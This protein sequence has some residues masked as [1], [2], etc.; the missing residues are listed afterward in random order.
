MGGSGHGLLALRVEA[1]VL[2]KAVDEDAE[3]GFDLKRF[4][5]NSFFLGKDLNKFADNLFDYVVHMGASF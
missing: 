5:L 1:G 4:E 2:D 3:M